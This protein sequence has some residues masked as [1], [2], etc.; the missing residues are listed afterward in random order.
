MA[1]AAFFYGLESRT[2]WPGARARTGPPSRGLGAV[3][4]LAGRGAGSGGLTLYLVPRFKQMCLALWVKQ[5]VMSSW[6]L[7]WTSM[8][9]L[10]FKEMDWTG[11]AWTCRLRS[12]Q[13]QAFWG[14]PSGK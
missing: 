6:L 7:T 8:Y 2:A 5:K 1:V 13:F 9:W 12:H 14:F 3:G 10:T 11:G 4:A